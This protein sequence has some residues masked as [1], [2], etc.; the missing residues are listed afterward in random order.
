MI[1]LAQLDKDKTSIEVLLDEAGLE[2]LR[3]I[4]NKQWKEPHLN[5]SNLYDFDHEHLTSKEWG[6]AELTPEF[7]S[8]D[9]GKIHSVKIVY[10]GEN[11]EALLS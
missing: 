5:T 11:G 9:A 10:L 1:L 6:G 8:S 2:L 4:I 3:G 7:T